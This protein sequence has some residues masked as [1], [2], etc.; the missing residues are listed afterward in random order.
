MEFENAPQQA[1]S[2]QERKAYFRPFEHN[3]RTV[4]GAPR[5]NCSCELKYAKADRLRL[6]CPECGKDRRC[7]QSPVP[8]KKRCKWHFGNTPSGPT[9]PRYKHG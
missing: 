1:D 2:E 5:R 3:D 9:H 8:G 6:R 7:T 4:C